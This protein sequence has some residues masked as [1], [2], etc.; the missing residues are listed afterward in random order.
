MTFLLNLSLAE[1]Q[2][3]EVIGK[4]TGPYKVLHT[5]VFPGT[6][7]TSVGTLGQMSTKIQQGQIQQRWERL[8]NHGQCWLMVSV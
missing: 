4:V 8:G 7:K 5:Q 6:Q 2:C 1:P 3:P